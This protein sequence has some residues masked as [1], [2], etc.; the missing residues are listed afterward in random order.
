M[1]DPI[2]I[3]ETQGDARACIGMVANVHTS[4]ATA[5]FRANEGKRRDKH[6]MRT[7]MHVACHACKIRMHECMDNPLGRNGVCYLHI[8]AHMCTHAYTCINNMHAST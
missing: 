2:N 3:H 1:H 5:R 4:R 7:S 8:H 6:S